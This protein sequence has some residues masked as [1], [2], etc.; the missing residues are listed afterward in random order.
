MPHRYTGEK[1]VADPRMWVPIPIE[2][3]SE[4]NH[5]VSD[6]QISDE[7]QWSRKKKSGYYKHNGQVNYSS[8]AGGSIPA[9]DSAQYSSPVEYQRNVPIDMNT[10]NDDH[11]A[12]KKK[13]G[14][15]KPNAHIQYRSG[16][17]GSIQ[18]QESSQYPST[19]D[20]QRNVPIKVNISH[21]AQPNHVSGAKQDDDIF[22]RK[23]R[24]DLKQF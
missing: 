21:S 23:R 18:S 5:Y 2:R 6:I 11:S 7:D 1:V 24:S 4:E 12:R 22:P 3:D 9:Q 20:R 13:S 19:A 16:A 15:Y 17:G 10:Y 14:Y 8:G